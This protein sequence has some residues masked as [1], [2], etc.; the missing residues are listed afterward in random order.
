MA[1][2]SPG[3]TWRSASTVPSESIQAK[4]TVPT[5]FS[6]L[7]PSGP[8]SSSRGLQPEVATYSS[9]TPS[10]R[11]AR[12]PAPRCWMGESPQSST[13]LALPVSKQSG[14]MAALVALLLRS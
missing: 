14:A 7:P 12:R 13:F 4:Q 9:E 5:G 6:A 8:L 2:R 10:G 3:N 1:A 11:L